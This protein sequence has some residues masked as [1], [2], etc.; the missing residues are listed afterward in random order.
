MHK[1]LAR[2]RARH[3]LLEDVEDA[4]YVLEKLQQGED[5]G[6]LAKELSECNS[7]QKG[8]DLG[9]FVSGQVAP[10][11][12]RAIYHLKIDEISEPVESEYGFH[13]IQRLAL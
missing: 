5:F 7:S 4:Q 1:S 3:I 10:E 9:L 12:E 6:E 13:I 11:V 2:Y 8:G